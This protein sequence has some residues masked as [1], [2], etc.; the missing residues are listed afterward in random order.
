MAQQVGVTANHVRD[1]S[2]AA[3]ETGAIT[4]N[5]LDPSQPVMWNTGGDY[6]YQYDSPTSLNPP[7]EFN[8]EVLAAR[9]K[10]DEA[11]K[12]AREVGPPRPTSATP[13]PP[14]FIPEDSDAIAICLSPDVC[15]SPE[16]PVPYQTW[17]RASDSRN[18]SPNVRSNGR[19]V[20][21]QDSVFFCCYGDEAGTGLGVKSNTVGDI[22]EPVTS[23]GTVRI[24][25]VWAQR[26]DDRCTLNS[27]NTLGEYSNSQCIDAHAAPDGNDQQD[28]AWYERTLDTVRDEGAHFWEGMTSTSDTA[29]AGE[30]IFNKVG[31]Y[32]N[33]PA[34]MGRDAQSVYENL[35]TGSEIWE[36]TKNVAYGA[37]HV[38]G[39]VWND[40][41]G[42]VNSAGS[43]V[44]DTAVDAWQ[45]V[46]KG[47]A[48]HGV[49]GAVG[50][51]AGLGL[52]I[53]NPLKKLRMLE[54]AAEAAEKIGDFEKAEQLRKEAERLRQA[55]KDG[56]DGTRSSKAKG[57]TPKIR[58]DRL[59]RIVEWKD[60]VGPDDIGT[61]TPTNQAARDHA[62]A[63]GKETDDAG[64]A[65][66]SNLGGS[67]TDLD[68]IFPQAPSV[69][70]GKFRVF[71]QNVADRIAST[72]QSA[73]IT[74]TPTYAGSS[75]RPSSMN[76]NVRF[77]DG[78]SISKD[79]PNP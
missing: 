8:D 76:Y 43:W 38:A 22:V 17:G 67:G 34:Q 64:H 3:V 54:R 39:D 73:D 27:G 74:L 9:V 18:Y 77:D 78:T 33:D 49:S 66:G 59:G 51:A 28:K 42:S 5:G 32:W 31:E 46:E 23:S 2:R 75:T 15:R 79:F 48:E 29:A 11:K 52:E 70:R 36:G 10:E 61:G 41:V 53:V 19:V 37:A 13:P 16:K 35:P 71:E 20:K 4:R 30:G 56:K 21:R 1:V 58:R 25:G 63:L 69:N 62:R 40:P 7:K 60:R 55:E 68:N 14:E 26:H 72:G 47:Y 45:G 50:A 24:N 65:R 57:K 12:E 44:K 6:F